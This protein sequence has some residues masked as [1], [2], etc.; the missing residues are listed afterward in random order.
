MYQFNFDVDTFL[1][2]SWQKR[3]R[4]I[5]GGFDNFRDP[6]SSDELAGLAMEEAIDSRLIL[7]KD[8][9]W[10]VSH[11]PFDHFDHFPD[12]HAQLIVQAAN[13][14]HSEVQKLATPFQLFPK[15]LMDDVM[16]CFSQPE[17]GVGPHIDQYDVFII[18]GMGKRHWRVGEKGSYQEANLETG[19]RQ[20]TGFDTAMDITMTA[21]DILYI[22]A[23]FPHEGE[24]IEASLSYSVGFRSPNAR[25]LLSHFA[26][27][28]INNDLGG[29]HYHDTEMTQRSE[30]SAIYPDEYQRLTTMM[31]RLLDDESSKKQWLG[32]YLSQSRHELDIVE[33]EQRWQASDIQQLLS[34]G[35]LLN[36]VS[37]LRTLYYP[38]T[39]LLFYVNGDTFHAPQGC[40]PI[41]FTLCNEDTINFDTLDEHVNSRDLMQLLTQLIN[42]GYWY[43]DDNLHELK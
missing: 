27:F 24:A 28:V 8:Q 17:G 22:P 1:T 3:P 18:Q 16:V 37:G 38:E 9:Q 33:P 26:D 31:Q 23:G 43:F 21:G 15:W 19:L 40:Q 32:A 7:N 12:R 5:K 35:A 29:D 13:H 11:G 14:W 20:I 30:P 41:V 36:K 25:E 39:P 34:N 42:A 10:Q 6:I 4:L 2:E